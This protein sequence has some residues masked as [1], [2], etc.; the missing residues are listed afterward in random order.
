MRKYFIHTLIIGLILY[1][2]TASSQKIDS[3]MS[4]YADQL[5]PEKIHIHFDKSVYN[6][7]ETIWYKIYILQRGDT[8]SH[9]VYLEWY[10]SEGKW[11]THTSSP[12]VL[13]TASGSFT[14]PDDYNG[15]SLQVKA[16]TSWMLNDD[17]AFSY[18]RQIT[19][20][21]NSSKKKKG[22]TV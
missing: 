10:D 9:N 12:L 14:I 3:M 20:N 17:P 6:R 19:V 7:G 18:Q 16:F 11:I 15:E 4:V 8:V 2:N 5:S 22:C 13:S 21:T 1:V